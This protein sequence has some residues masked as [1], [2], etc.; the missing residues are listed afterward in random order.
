MV[1]FDHHP[2]TPQQRWSCRTS[3]LQGSGQREEPSIGGHQRGELLKTT[4]WFQ[5]LSNIETMDVDFLSIIKQLNSATKTSSE[6]T[7][8]VITTLAK[9]TNQGISL[10]CPAYTS[11][12]FHHHTS[13]HNFFAYCFRHCVGL[14]ASS[15]SGAGCSNNRPGA[16][17]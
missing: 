3:S 11:Y 15:S 10:A 1:D 2:D 7:P 8:T 17:L 16:K 5:T 6:T 13:L 4:N 14:Q 9:I 12:C